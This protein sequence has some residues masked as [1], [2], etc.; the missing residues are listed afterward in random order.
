MSK[1]R[2]GE[3]GAVCYL[4]K[5]LKIEELEAEVTRLKTGFQGAC[6]TC[7]TVGELNVRQE[8]ELFDLKFV[9]ILCD[10]IKRERYHKAELKTAQS[11]SH[12]VVIERD[13]LRTEKVRLRNRLKMELSWHSA[14]GNFDRVTAIKEVLEVK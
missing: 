3:I 7:E 1:C 10:M 4:C 9:G 5:V 8:A 13:N 11:F 6:Y 14:M 2:H 12:Y